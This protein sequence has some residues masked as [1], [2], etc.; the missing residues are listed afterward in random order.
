MVGKPDRLWLTVEAQGRPT[1]WIAVV[2][3]ECLLLNIA[4]QEVGRRAHRRRIR[5]GNDGLPIRRRQ[6]GKVAGPQFARLDVQPTAADLKQT[7]V[8]GISG[9]ERQ[10]AP[11]DADV[12]RRRAVPVGGKQSV[13]ERTQGT[14]GVRGRFG[15]CRPRAT[16]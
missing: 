9:G 15:N 16:E 1:S 8:L 2:K 6:G 14:E 12:G 3:V 13:E 4:E 10:Y 5:P 7:L 11:V